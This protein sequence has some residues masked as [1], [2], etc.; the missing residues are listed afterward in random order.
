MKAA[1]QA[2]TAAAI[3]W[4]Q[5]LPL[6]VVGC[7]L[8]VVECNGTVL[9]V[10]LP[11]LMVEGQQMGRDKEMVQS[12][13]ALGTEREK[14]KQGSWLAF[15]KILQAVQRDL[16]YLVMAEDIGLQQQEDEEEEVE[17]TKMRK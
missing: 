2:M 4:S 8:A 16:I 17:E 15:A 11:V 6:V 12:M 1:S 14:Q 5:T 7:S 13:P 9:G 3:V 10:L